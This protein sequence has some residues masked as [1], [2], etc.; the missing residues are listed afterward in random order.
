MPEYPA[1]GVI[2]M[3]VIIKRSDEYR[4]ARALELGQNVPETVTG[5][6][7]IADFCQ[8]ARQMLL[9]WWGKYPEMFT[10]VDIRNDG[11][12]HTWSGSGGLYEVGADIEADELTPDYVVQH[13][14]KIVKLAAEQRAKHETKQR[15]DAI[16]ADA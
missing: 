13:M 2:I 14:E 1:E 11:T 8:P 6:V 5:D 15:E 7:D 12:I 4:K 3:K 10:A 16:K 9:D